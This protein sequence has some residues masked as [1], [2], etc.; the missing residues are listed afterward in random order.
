MR[1]AP[2]DLLYDPEDEQTQLDPYPL[3]R[4]LRDE[5]PV[6]RQER[7]RFWALSRFA[8]VYAA[9]DDHDVFCSRQG[10]T[11]DPAAA[12]QAGV[13]PMMV[14]TDPPDHTKLRRLIN[15]GLTPKRV[16]DLEPEVRAGIVE[17]IDAVRAARAGDLVTNVAVPV[18]TAMVGRFLGVPETDRTRFHHWAG[19]VVAGTSGAAFH[20]EHH[21]AVRELYAYFHDLIECRRGAPTDDLIG[22]LIASEIDGV[23]LTTQEI[24]GFC[25]NIVVGG[26]ETTTNLIANGM[27]LLAAHPETA[28]RLVVEP[29]LIPSAIEEFLRLE[30]PVAGL[31]RTTTRAVTLHGVTI[32]AGEKVLLMFGAANRDEREFADPDRLDLDR[33]L[34]RH[35]AFG[36]GAHYCIGAALARLMGRVAFEELTTRL[37]DSRVDVARGRRLRAAVSRGWESLPVAVRGAA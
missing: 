35:L 37:G 5:C 15:R 7:L 31:C 34:E 29:G 19:A 27:A 36:Y 6:Y 23:H 8:D 13:L 12:E 3:Y 30:T 25:F 1:P 18:P 4:R 2:T 11:W 33:G 24:L 17:K 9:L 22:T 21:R 14:T 10:L 16:A 28:R 26:I 32:P 20:Q